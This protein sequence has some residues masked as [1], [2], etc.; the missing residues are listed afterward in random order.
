MYCT[1]CGADIGDSAYCPNCGTK[2]GSDTVKPETVNN[3]NNNNNNNV[4]NSAETH[5]APKL[6][7]YIAPTPPPNNNTGKII[8]I[9]AV[10]VVILAAIALIGIKPLMASMENKK[11]YEEG[12]LLYEQ[13]SYE[14]ALAVF[15]SLGDYEDSA[16]KV[17]LCNDAIAE[18]AYQDSLNSA[19]EVYNAGDYTS[20]ITLFNE[21]D[22]SGTNPEIQEWIE[23][24]KEG[25]YQYASEQ[26]NNEN[27]AEANTYFAVISGYKDADDM[28]AESTKAVT[29]LSAVDL[30]NEGNYD[31]ALDVFETMEGYKEA[32]SYATD[33]RVMIMRAKWKPAFIN[34]IQSDPNSDEHKYAFIYV[35]NNSVPELYVSA[36][37]EADGDKICVFNYYGNIDEYHLHRTGG[38]SYIKGSGLVRNENGNM[39]TMAVV[40]Y[41]LSNLV[42]SEIHSGT[43]VYHYVNGVESYQ[44]TWDGQEV[45]KIEFDNLDNA[46]FNSS[47]AQRVT[48]VYTASEMINYINTNF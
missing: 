9:S 8:I 7:D 30:Y 47:K 6:S 37:I 35:D 25:V 3:N 46:A 13:G 5:S 17:N 38:M 34:Y 27:Y 45:S 48:T 2:A 19:I 23:K 21:L 22:S 32:D 31:A 12:A 11:A 16:E 36:T 28:A 39:G 14:E 18:A 29:Y 1:N 24:C 42:M 20:A 4:E 26:Y 43:E 41:S 33:C 40:I 44:Y 15:E 10:C